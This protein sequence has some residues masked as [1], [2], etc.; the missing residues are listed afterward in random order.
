MAFLLEIAPAHLV[1]PVLERLGASARQALL[2]GT[3]SLPKG[4]LLESVLRRGNPAETAAL[5]GHPEAGPDL[6]VRLAADT[7]DPA[8]A[9]RLFRHVRASREVRVR[10]MRLVPAAELLDQ[11]GW[12]NAHT[13]PGFPLQR[14]VG[15]AVEHDDPGV[16]VAALTLLDP[17]VN[18]L[19]AHAV[20]LRGCLRLLDLAGP[21]IA[22][23][24]AARTDAALRRLWWHRW[25]PD[26]VLNRAL[27]APTDRASLLAA[28]DYLSSTP[29]LIERLRAARAGDYNAS[30]VGLLLASPRGPLDWAAIRH[31]HAEDRLTFEMIRALTDEPDCPPEFP[32]GVAESLDRL[33]LPPRAKATPEELA[34]V[35]RRLRFLPPGPVNDVVRNAH[36]WHQLSTATILGQGEPAHRALAL[37]AHATPAALERVRTAT[38]RATRD[39]LGDRA[40]A[41]VVALTLLP[42]F[43]GSVRELLDTAAAVAA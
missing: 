1:E 31:A 42:D 14:C 16:V 9:A 5:A 43:P 37:F 6:L 7:A 38:A 3:V 22:A 25:K 30:R 23:D 18:D 34:R 39:T 24:A 8:T 12:Y 41:W 20:L 36:E 11:T 4:V 32:Q 2:V 28:L 33:R 19:G 15:A 17:E 40:D 13:A 29:V 10:A 26:P 21:Q 27:D 35:L